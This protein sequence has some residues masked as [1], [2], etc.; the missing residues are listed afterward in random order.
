MNKENKNTPKTR[1]SGKKQKDEPRFTGTM[2][3][4]QPSVNTGRIR[5]TPGGSLC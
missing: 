1:E 3:R 5:R 2:E 4:V